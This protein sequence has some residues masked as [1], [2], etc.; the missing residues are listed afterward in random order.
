MGARHVGLGPGIVDEDK[1]RGID[2]ALISAPLGAA[3]PYVGAVLLTRDQRLLW[4]GAPLL[5]AG[6]FRLPATDSE[7]AGNADRGSRD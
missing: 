7:G 3:A 4:D 6:D 1:P 2:P 5:S